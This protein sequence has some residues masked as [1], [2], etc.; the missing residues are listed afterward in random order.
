MI[1]VQGTL[2]AHIAA[3]DPSCLVR[4][5]V[6]HFKQASGKGPA[7]IAM[8]IEEAR[9]SQALSMVSCVPDDVGMRKLLNPHVNLQED[10]R[11]RELPDE[12]Y[13]LPEL[14]LLAVGWNLVI[15]TSPP[16]PH[17]WLQPADDRIGCAYKLLR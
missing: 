12:V 9:E 8:A 17:L 5:I 7:E 2:L 14:G 13:E 4:S 11:L 10:F 3:P 15:L 16:C 6:R 1:T